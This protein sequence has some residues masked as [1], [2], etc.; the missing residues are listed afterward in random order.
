[1][2]WS[3]ERQGPRV[4]IQVWREDRGEGL[5]KAYVAGPGGRSLLGTLIPE[6]GRL[7]LR[8]TLSVDALQRQGLWPVRQVTEELIYS[9]QDSPVRWDDPVLLRAASRLPRHTMLR[10]E[11]GFT[12]I[13]P[14]EPGKP[15]P[16]P[17]LFCF[18]CLRQGRLFFSFHSG[19]VPYI[20][21]EMGENK[22]DNR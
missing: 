6:E 17:A 20:S 9:F 7:T 3:L 18:A 11:D 14:F 8:R 2:A 5:Y 1:M 21:N 12:L 10:Q 19:G 13:F 22:Q 4:V 16:I 15:F